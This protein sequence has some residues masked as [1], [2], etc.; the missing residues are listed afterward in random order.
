V[1]DEL[2]WM[3]KER[4]VSTLIDYAFPSQHPAVFSVSDRSCSEAPSLLH[5]TFHNVIYTTV[6]CPLC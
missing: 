6:K 2:E 3:W 5:A 1:N 4:V